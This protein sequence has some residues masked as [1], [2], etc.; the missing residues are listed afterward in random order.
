MV[1]EAGFVMIESQK[2]CCAVLEELLSRHPSPLGYTALF[3]GYFI[4]LKG[5]NPYK[6]FEKELFSYCPGCGTKLP[7]CLENEFFSIVKK[8]FNIT[9]TNLLKILQEEPIP[10]EFKSDEWWKKR[11]L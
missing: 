3:R 6:G 7:P 10:S 2:S 5:G 1:E 9:H 8:E 11:K 4:I